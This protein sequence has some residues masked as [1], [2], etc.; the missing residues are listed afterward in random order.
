[1]YVFQMQ[2]RRIAREIS[3]HLVQQPVDCHR[4]TRAT[5][6]QEIEA[7]APLLA[8]CTFAYPRLAAIGLSPYL[9]IPYAIR[10]KMRTEIH[11]GIPPFIYGD[12]WLQ[13][14]QRCPSEEDP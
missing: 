1:M 8:T 2:Q 12:D 11:P 14:P 3:P 7:V 6:A 13:G 4:A 9:V 10:V 5:L